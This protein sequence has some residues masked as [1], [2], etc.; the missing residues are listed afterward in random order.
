MKHTT[1]DLLTSTTTTQTIEYA[2]RE[3]RQLGYEEMARIVEKIIPIFE[4]LALKIPLQTPEA[5]LLKDDLISEIKNLQDYDQLANDLVHVGEQILES[6][7]RSS[8][9]NLG[10][11][12]LAWNG[13]D[14]A[15]TRI[16]LRA[17][18]KKGR[19]NITLTYRCL[20]PSL[21]IKPLADQAQLVFM[22][23]TLSP[24]NTFK[25]ILG[26]N[27]VVKELPDPFPQE[28]RLN[29]IVPEI[30]TKFT[31]R[32]ENM[33][34]KIAGYCAALTNNIPGNSVI[35][36]PSYQLRDT[37]LPY[38]QKLSD[39]TI[40]TEQQSM[41]KQ[42][43]DQL[44]ETFKRYKDSGAVLLGVSNAN[45]GEGI[46]L[47]GDYL[48]G[49]IIVGLP[50]AKPDLE[51]QEL[52]RYYDTRF[53]A[54]WEYGYVFPALTKTLQNAGRCIRSDTDRGV[55]IFLD[56]RYNLPQYKK[57]FPKEWHMETVQDPIRAVKEF[58]RN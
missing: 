28:N 57:F 21:I 31:H 51:T 47:P 30:T 19:P 46:D 5:L 24:I 34:K 6:K 16:I 17:F 54:G 25:D 3:V 22:S 26:I 37:V 4:H 40:L 42:E 32:D 53:G 44:L 50:L 49:V 2:A 52:I 58:F 9:H 8:A 35:F 14:E 45:F 55:I 23:G 48:K 13:P 18:T 27:A 29:L 15:Y 11:F 10:T 7:K 36:F 33:F 56:D 12:L 39:K 38:F 1:R 43:R 20:D 41:H